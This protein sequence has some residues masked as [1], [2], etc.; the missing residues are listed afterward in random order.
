MLVGP[1]PRSRPRIIKPVPSGPGPVHPGMGLPGP[2]PRVMGTG[3]L[4]VLVIPAPAAAPSGVTAVYGDGGHFVTYIASSPAPA[5]AS[6]TSASA[7]ATSPS[8]GPL[9]SAGVL[10]ELM[11][12]ATPVHGAWGSGRLLR[13]SLLSVLQTSNGTLLI[14]AVTPAVLFADAAGLK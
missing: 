8:P 7:V 9:A 2:R 5:S 13:T 12:A 10:R 11:K 4:S 1:G 3:W 14:G 6:S